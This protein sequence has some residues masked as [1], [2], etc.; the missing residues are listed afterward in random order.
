MTDPDYQSRLLSHMRAERTIFVN[1]GLPRHSLKLPYSVIKVNS[2]NPIWTEP[3]GIQI[4][5]NEDW[6]TPPDKEPQP[7]AN[8]FTEDKI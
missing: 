8:F 4:P 6:V 2:S 1:P 3:V 5:K 7:P